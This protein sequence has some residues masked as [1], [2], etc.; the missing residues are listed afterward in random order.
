MNI[1][2][3][4]KHFIKNIVDIQ[5]ESY[6]RVLITESH[7]VNQY[8]FK[9]LSEKLKGNVFAEED[10]KIG[11]ENNFSNSIIFTPTHKDLVIKK[12]FIVALMSATIEKAIEGTPICASLI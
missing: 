8:F 6:P 4:V 1:F 3:Y 10:I 9:D 11:W 7:E 2:F 5:K 12:P